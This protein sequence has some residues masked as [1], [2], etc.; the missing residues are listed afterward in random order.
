MQGAPAYFASVPSAVRPGA[1][2]QAVT[3]EALVSR[4]AAGDKAA[5]RVL[6]ARHQVRVYRFVLRIVGNATD[7]EDL[8]SEVFLEAWRQAARFKGR[9]TVSTWLLAIGRNKAFSALRRQTN[10]QLDETVVGTIEDPADDPEAAARRRDRSETLRLCLAALSVEH[11]EVVDLV[12]YHEKS[13]EEVAAIIGIPKN[14]VK[15]RVFYARK[16]LADLLATAG[17]DRTWISVSD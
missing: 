12:Y 2:T 3:D 1:A 13:I 4:I 9:S 10:E 6:F 5:V 14:T 8:T 7:A 15:T 11:R 17:V 16:R